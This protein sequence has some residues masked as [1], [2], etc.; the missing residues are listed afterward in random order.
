MSTTI[1]EGRR[2]PL[3]SVA[4]IMEKQK[5]VRERCLELYVA[6]VCENIVHAHRER[7]VSYSKFMSILRS[8]LAQYAREGFGGYYLDYH[9]TA[10]FM[11]LGDYLMVI[12]FNANRKCLKVFDEVFGCEFYGYWDNT[13][14]ED[15][16]SEEDWEARGKEWNAALGGDGYTAPI[17][18][19]VSI[20]IIRDGAWDLP[21]AATLCKD[22]R[23][24]EIYEKPLE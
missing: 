18:A 11:P 10:S 2:I 15:G 7:G 23:V 1:Y 17:V 5:I 14:P 6:E 21:M 20:T 12:P 22:P 8:E 3:I 13:D 24:N 16:V 4:E 19:G 9:F